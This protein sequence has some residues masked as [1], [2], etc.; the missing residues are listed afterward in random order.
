MLPNFLVVGAAKAGTT[1]LYH[2]LKQ[3][4]EIYMSPVKEPY[5]FAYMDS[6]PNIKGPNS[7]WNDTV[8]YNRADYEALFNGA[9]DKKMLGECSPLYLFSSAAPTNIKNVIPNCKI[10]ILLR[11]PLDRAYSHYLHWRINCY[12]SLS[13]E[14]AIAA[15]EERAKNGWLWVYQYIEVSRYSRQIAE[16]K[17]LFNDKHLFIGLFETLIENP[18]LFMKQVFSF[19]EINNEFTPSIEVHNKTLIPKSI[20]LNRFYRRSRII[21]AVLK[22]FIPKHIRASMKNYFISKNQ[23]SKQKPQIENQLK[24]RLHS[25]FVDDVKQL[26]VMIKNDLSIWQY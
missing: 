5:Y 7:G 17:R 15:Q 22:P 26:Q 1:S 20:A 9:G 23:S 25:E 3:H 12:E 16:Y 11:Q 19:L 8:I 24:R 21:K 13:F 14:D 4:P 2:Y 6:R 18:A 10:I